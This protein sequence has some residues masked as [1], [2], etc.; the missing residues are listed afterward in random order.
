MMKGKSQ[1]TIPIVFATD[2]NYVPYCAVAIHSLICNMNKQNRY[3]IYILFDSL[4]R[5]SI[6]TLQSLSTDAA[7]IRCIC[8]HERMDALRISEQVHLT[9]ATTYR[10]LIPEIF[11]KYD[12]IIYL[13]SDIIVR[14]DIVDLYKMELDGNILGAVKGR[15]KREDIEWMRHHLEETL[16]I[17]TDHFFNA[18]VLLIDTKVFNAK[19]IK[20]KAFDILTKRD[21]LTFMDQD[22]LNIVCENQV[23][24]IDEFWN[25]EC[26]ALET[27]DE[28]VSDNSNTEITGEIKA[29]I[30]HFDGTYKP[31]DYPNLTCAGIFW[32]YA[33]KTIYYEEILYRMNAHE[34]L[35]LASIVQKLKGCKRIAVYGAGR[36]GR[37]LVRKI[38]GTNICKISCWVDRDPQNK[39]YFGIHVC[40]IEK[41]R[42]TRFDH[43]IIAIEDKKISE[44]VKEMLINQGFQE[45]VILTL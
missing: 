6:D 31:W 23:K 20:K 19:Q 12:R 13:D 28:Y 11:D 14:S 30:I 38:K 45:K 22:A 35:E 44:N 9:V 29:G 15:Y 27:G 32:E 33:R 2:E 18:G 42:N 25:Y 7:H 41:L 4:T 36:A 39:N 8:V 43:V 24:Y 21:D 1:V 40:E 37:E 17:S 34:I 5:R 3:E 26:G 10:I 16:G